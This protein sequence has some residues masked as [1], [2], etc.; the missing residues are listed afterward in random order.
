MAIHQAVKDAGS[1]WLTDGRRNSG[2]RS[3]SVEFDIHIFTVD[4]LFVPVNWQSA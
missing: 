4:E 1:R 2:D 3:I